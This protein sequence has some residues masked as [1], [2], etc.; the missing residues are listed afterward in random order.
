M[1]I[2]MSD[3]APPQVGST[4]EPIIEEHLEMSANAEEVL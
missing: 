3:T 2:S 4:S 1:M